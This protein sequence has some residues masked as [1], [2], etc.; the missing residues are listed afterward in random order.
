MTAIVTSSDSCYV[1]CVQGGMTYI[2]VAYFGVNR[3]KYAKQKAQKCPWQRPRLHFSWIPSG[4]WESSERLSVWDSELS[5][6]F[7]S[8][9]S[10]SVT[11]ICGLNC[12]SLM[13]SL[14]HYVILVTA[15]NEIC[16]SNYLGQRTGLQR[17]I[18]LL[19]AISEFLFLSGFRAT[20]RLGLGVRFHSGSCVSGLLLRPHLEYKLMWLVYCK[21]SWFWLESLS[22]NWLVL[23]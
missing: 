7:C 19:R 12:P 18:I 21:R 20:L 23:S 17:P 11:S 4:Q 5:E 10:S 8:Q 1:L 13:D 3:P 9:R 16:Q 22:V 15:S 14:S 2:S 6:C